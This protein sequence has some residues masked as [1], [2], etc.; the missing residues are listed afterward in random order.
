MLISCDEE[1]T[2]EN[3]LFSLDFETLKQNGMNID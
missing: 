2:V 1:E 3:I